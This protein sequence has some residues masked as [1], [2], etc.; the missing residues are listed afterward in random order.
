MNR[1]IEFRRHVHG[2]ALMLATAL[3][4]LACSSG[5]RWQAPPANEFLVPEITEDGSKFFIFRR[6]YL[7]AQ[8]PRPGRD[9]QMEAAGSRGLRVGEFEVEARLATIMQ[10][11]GYC[12]EGFFELYRE[13]TFQQFTVRGECR[14]DA[15]AEDRLTFINE[16]PLNGP[17]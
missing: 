10:H 1:P 7:Q 4:V 3:S 17:F 12:R 5:P 2:A 16:I 15:T 9:V 13:Q 8:T 14:E 11:T 6:D